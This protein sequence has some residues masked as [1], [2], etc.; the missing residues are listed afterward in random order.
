VEVLIADYNAFRQ[1]EEKAI[2]EWINFYFRL[3]I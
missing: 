2:A 1:L 3:Q